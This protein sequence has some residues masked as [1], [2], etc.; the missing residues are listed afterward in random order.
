VIF[1]CAGAANVTHK[2]RAQNA[3]DPILGDNAAKLM[4]PNPK[5]RQ[6]KET[7][8]PWKA[9]VLDCGGC[10]RAHARNIKRK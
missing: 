2:W 8:P 7:E 3:L 10:Q 1:T 9:V 6:I 5:Q 4:S